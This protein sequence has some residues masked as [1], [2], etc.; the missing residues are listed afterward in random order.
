MWCDS[1]LLVLCWVCHSTENSYTEVDI[2]K[3]T[4]ATTKQALAFLKDAK[5]DKV[6]GKVAEL[7]KDFIM[8][9]VKSFKVDLVNEKAKTVITEWQAALDFECD[10]KDTLG[11]LLADM[12]E[13]DADYI[14]IETYYMEVVRIATR[15]LQSALKPIKAHLGEM[16]KAIL[17]DDLA[18]FNKHMKAT[19]DVE[20][21]KGNFDRLKDM[22]M[23][24]RKFELSTVS[25]SG[26][27]NLFMHLM[28]ARL[29]LSNAYSPRKLDSCLEKA[30]MDVPT[31]DFETAMNLDTL[32]VENMGAECNL[33]FKKDDTFTYK[34]EKVRA[35]FHTSIAI[36][37]MCLVSED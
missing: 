2:M 26:F 36:K 17:V 35:K 34:A 22:V 3:T 16:Y 21:S 19:F 30:I 29:V 9:Q 6:N 5:I 13:N 7:R 1:A 25:S 18:T 11:V 28:T 20:I 15:R 37:P 8:K 23:N 12:D 24:G 33:K 32:T 4:I 31:I 14:A 27:N 10:M